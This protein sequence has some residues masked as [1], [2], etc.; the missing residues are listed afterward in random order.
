MDRSGT[1]WSVY[2]DQ[3]EVVALDVVRMAM[4]GQMTPE[5]LDVDLQLDEF[6][7]ERIPL[8]WTA[9][10]V[11]RAGGRVTLKGTPAAPVLSGNINVSRFGPSAR[12]LNELPKLDGHVSIRVEDGALSASTAIENF[13]PGYLS[14]SAVMPCALSILPFQCS[15]DPTSGSGVLDSVLDLEVC[16]GLAILNNQ[17]VNGIF[18]SELIWTNGVPGWF[19]EH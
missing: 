10:F 12:T 17:R 18:S 8:Q 11:G 16:N 7:I 4:S 13:T 5:K 15:V 2:A 3:F 1:V 9:P 6:D 14:A 19:C